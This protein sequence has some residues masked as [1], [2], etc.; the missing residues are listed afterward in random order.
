MKPKA[1]LSSLPVE[2]LLDYLLPLLSNKDLLSLS[3]ANRAFYQLA[4]DD[5]LWKRKLQGDFNFPVAET[6]RNTGWK[7]L[8]RRLAHPGVY[9]WGAR[10]NGRLGLLPRLLPQTQV[11][12]GVPFPVHLRIPNVRIVD[13]I[14]GGMYV[15]RSRPS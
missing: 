1:A 7:L 2:T 15:T 9:V 4:S 10:G 14:A 11:Q 8:Y 3:A 6:A 5:T 12:G 13:L